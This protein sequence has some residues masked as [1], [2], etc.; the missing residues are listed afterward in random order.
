ML[1]LFARTEIDN[2]YLSTIISPMDAI[3]FATVLCRYN[4]H[5]YL[6]FHVKYQ[7]DVQSV[8]L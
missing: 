3:T 7:Y 6:F 4:V 2:V 8:E 5:I 1:L